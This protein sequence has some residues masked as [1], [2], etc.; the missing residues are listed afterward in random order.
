MGLDK[1]RKLKRGVD[2]FPIKEEVKKLKRRPKRL[3]FIIPPGTKFVPDET[4]IA[5]TG[6]FYIQAPDGSYWRLKRRVLRR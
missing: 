3:D 5:A 1:M 6:T 2:M 4:L